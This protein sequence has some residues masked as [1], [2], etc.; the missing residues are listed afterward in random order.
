M[1]HKNESLSEW[2]SVVE[3][4]FT[5][6][7]EFDECVTIDGCVTMNIDDDVLV[8]DD[9]T[10]EVLLTNA[11]ERGNIVLDGGSLKIRDNDGTQY[12]SVALNHLRNII[13]VATV[14]INI[15]GDVL[16]GDSAKVCAVVIDPEG[17][18]PVNFSFEVNITYHYSNGMDQPGGICI[19]Y[20]A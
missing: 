2:Y 12:V 7:V 1:S 3:E 5:L 14:A 17:D 16:E 13:S 15:M 8:D 6:S 19:Y 4:N 9:R 11:T 18:C 10:F 20:H